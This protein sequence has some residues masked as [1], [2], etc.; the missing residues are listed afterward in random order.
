MCHELLRLGGN[1]LVI[2]GIGPETAVFHITSRERHEGYELTAG[3]ARGITMR[4][5]SSMATRMWIWTWCW[6]AG[7]VHDPGR[8]SGALGLAVVRIGRHLFLLTDPHASHHER[9]AILS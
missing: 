3:I 1:P 6:F 8:R 9:M 7:I 5:S 4:T 2:C